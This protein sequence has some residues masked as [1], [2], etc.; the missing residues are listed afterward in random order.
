MKPFRL[1]LLAALLGGCATTPMPPKAELTELR[2]D[3]RAVASVP[4]IRRYAAAPLYGAQ[5][6][7]ERAAETADPAE[8]EHQ[9]YVARRYLEIAQV[10]TNRELSEREVERLAAQRNEVRR[11][12]RAEEEAEAGRRAEALEAELAALE[13][14]RVDRGVQ[15]TLQGVLFETGRAGLTPGAQDELQVLADFLR[16]HPKRG[17]MIEGHTDSFGSA[18]FNRILSGQRAEAV[19]QALV[20]RG[21]APE[22]IVTRG[23]G[24]TRPIASNATR[25]GRQLNRR[26]EVVILAEGLEPPPPGNE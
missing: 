23:Y 14:R 20:S 3:Y 10:L 6:A 13:A 8:Y 15:V 19:K 16:E 12:R 11:Q 22:R 25:A 26:V 9:I 4:E 1:A 18:S 7:I 21:V 5:Q 2:G 17:V 24:E